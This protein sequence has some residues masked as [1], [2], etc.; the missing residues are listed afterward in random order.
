[1]L[2]LPEGFGPKDLAKWCVDF[3]Q[4]ARVARATGAA[5]T[6]DR[7]ESVEV[8]AAAT[9]LVCPDSYAASLF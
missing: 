4:T 1:M 3:T 8:V 5:P 6:F 9:V 2:N 7:V